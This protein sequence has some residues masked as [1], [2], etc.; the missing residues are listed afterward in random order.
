[1]SALTAID[2]GYKELPHNI[3]AE[4]SVLGALLANNDCGLRVAEILEAGDFF[5]P[6]HQFVYRAASRFVLEG[7]LANAV[8]LAQFFIAERTLTEV[9]GA[10]YL[11]RL[12]G[13][14]VSIRNVEHYARIVRD[15]SRRRAIIEAC[16]TALSEAS[17]PD[18]ERDAE[19]VVDDLEG[20]LAELRGGTVRTPGMR[21]IATALLPVIEALGGGN[22]ALA[23]PTGLGRLD[24]LIG[25]WKRSKFV[26]LGGRPSMGKSA[27]AL[28]L[29]LRAAEKGHGAGY[30][31]LE[32]PDEELS[33]RALCGL[34]YSRQQPIHYFR[35]EQD[36]LRPEERERLRQAAEPLK[37]LPLYIDDAGSSTLA[38]IRSRARRLAAHFAEQG[39]RLELLIVDHLTLI[40]DSGRWRE[41]KVA[42]VSEVSAGLKELAKELDCCVLAPTQLNRAVEARDNKRPTLADL[43]ETGAIEQDAD[44]V[45][46]VY[47]EAYYHQRK[48]P[49]DGYGEAHR[50]ARERWRAEH[51]GIAHDMEVIVAKQRGGPT[52]SVTL[53]T[54]IGC[55][56][57]RDDAPTF[58][59][60]LQD[61]S[62]G[63]IL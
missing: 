16:E 23:I 54:D 18:P 55:N 11:G 52:G 44:L 59:E 34:A 43:R 32:M 4:Q 42:A 47:R 3:E 62:E 37:T 6:A 1:M 60:T 45:M 57:I 7:R 22:K 20:R 10:Q 27:L 53:W 9:G 56:V 40:K 8:T 39:R 15:L 36:R 17:T 58:R 35:V 5:E 2:G 31:S 41:N 26:V 19:S 61:D 25:G 49:S 24:E 21:S 33:A 63:I 30:V 51:D 50:A 28:E 38:Q 46:F 12:I 48:K 14:A 29:A 13:A